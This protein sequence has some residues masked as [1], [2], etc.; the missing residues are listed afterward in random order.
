MNVNVI[1]ND[2]K[3]FIK[4]HNPLKMKIPFTLYKMLFEN[5]INWYLLAQVFGILIIVIADLF[6]RLDSYMIKKISIGNIFLMTILLVPK[7]IWFTMPFVIMFG[8]IMAISGLYSSNEL[9]AVFT[10]GISYS[11][12]T[13]PIIVFGF[14]LSISMI[15]I[16][17]YGVVHAMRYRDKLY[18]KLTSE[19][20]EDYTNITL[21]SEEDGVFWHVNDLDPIRNRLDRVIVFKIDENYRMLWRINAAYAQYSKSGWVFYTGIERVWD[22]NGEIKNEIRFNRKIFS[23]PDK[24]AIFK[25]SEYDIETMNI[26]E[27]K[28]R[29]ALLERLN[30]EHRKEL[31]NYYKKFSFPF[32]LIIFS[33]FAIGVSTLSKIYI[34]L[35]ALFLSIAQAIVYYIVQFL[36]LDNLAYTGIITPFMGAWLT[37]FIFLPISVYLLVTA[38]T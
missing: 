17:S 21:R 15:F 36:I 16:D 31:T 32:I 26:E 34:L 6:M 19:K 24:P 28:D 37:L 3:D 7:A 30:V 8:I 22:E 10:S 27:A 1:I 2:A 9:I 38:K 33:I 23:F 11:K 4:K 5:F 13:A 14:F 18:Q 29:I 35:T 25:S 12:F 20:S